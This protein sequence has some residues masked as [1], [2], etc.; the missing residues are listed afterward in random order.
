MSIQL[1]K[2]YQSPEEL[3]ALLSDRGLAIHDKASSCRYIRHIGYYRLSAYLYPFLALPKESQLFKPDSTLEGAFMLYR[4]DK[5]LRMFL[6]N[7]IEKIEV[8]FR[9]A[10][11][12][13]VANETG[14][15]FWMTDESMFASQGKFNRTMELIKKEMDGSKEDFILHFKKK[16]CDAFPPAWILVEILPL[17]VLTR[18]Y[19]NIRSH[20]LKKKVAACFELPVPVFTSW[21]TVITLTRNS[22]CHHSRVWNR[23]YAI[24]PMVVKKMKR[25]WISDG[26]SPLRTFYE[27][28]IIK[29]FVDRVS[30]QNDMKEHLMDLL[31]LFPAVDVKAMGFPE[32]WQEEPIWL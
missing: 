22:C 19:E 16:Y 12:N 4:F 27:I 29:W 5:K 3:V 30:P 23:V 7:E 28:C 15:I 2:R 18:I 17:G 13:V 14:N 20:S 32:K 26:I 21:L 10:L 6:F 31:S 24:S 11:A 25:P 1:A 9:S 8:A